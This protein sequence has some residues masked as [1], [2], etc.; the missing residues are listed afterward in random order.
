M[1]KTGGIESGWGKTAQ[2]L[3]CA[4]FMGFEFQPAQWVTKNYC[5]KNR[6]FLEMAMKE[7]D[8][9]TGDTAAMRRVKHNRPYYS[10]LDDDQIIDL[11]HKSDYP[12]LSRSDVAK[13]LGATYPKNPHKI[14]I[15]CVL[16]PSRSAQNKN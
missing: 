4:K 13:A 14:Y 9:E 8:A 1:Q 11:I 2:K 5:E 7:V 12:D 10:S 6:D 15:A 16:L 3:E